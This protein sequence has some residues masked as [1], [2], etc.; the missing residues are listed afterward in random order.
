MTQDVWPSNCWA[1]AYVVYPKKFEE[2]WAI[3]IWYSQRWRHRRLHKGVTIGNCRMNR[4][5]F[6][7]ELVLHALIFSTGSSACI[8]S[9]LCCVRLR[10][11]ENQ[12]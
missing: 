10:S 4:L 6:P 2:P 1:I 3:W 8:W 5:L 7:D 12:L 11:N 9:I